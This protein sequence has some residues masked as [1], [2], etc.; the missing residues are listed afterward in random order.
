MARSPSPV[1]IQGLLFATILSRLLISAPFTTFAQRAFS[2]TMN[3]PS[4]S[5]VP[6]RTSVPRFARNA[7]I[8]AGFEAGK[9]LG[10]GGQ[11]ERRGHA[12]R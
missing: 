8:R 12:L 1:E 4:A 10:H 9:R 5:S 3:A 2:L 6:A 7:L 11:L